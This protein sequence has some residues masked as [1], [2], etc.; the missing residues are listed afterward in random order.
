VSCPE[1]LKPYSGPPSSSHVPM[2]P[3][4]SRRYSRSRC[5]QSLRGE[6]RANGEALSPAHALEGSARKGARPLREQQHPRDPAT[7]SGLA[8][9]GSAATGQ[10]EP[11]AALGISESTY[12]RRKRKGTLDKPVTIKKTVKPAKTVT[13]NDSAISKTPEKRVIGRPIQPGQVLNPKG[14]RA[15]SALLSVSRKQLAALGR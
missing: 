14:S 5:W 4:R 10:A 12:Y 8:S 13:V 7:A 3:V 9:R 1:A 2:S 6:H 11:W 15:I